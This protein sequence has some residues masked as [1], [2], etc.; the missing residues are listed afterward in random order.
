[1]RERNA[2]LLALRIAP[3]PN[4][5][6]REMSRLTRKKQVV[7]IPIDVL[8]AS[9]EKYFNYPEAHILRKATLDKIEAVEEYIRDADETP[10]M[11][12]TTQQIEKLFK[13]LA[14]NKTPGLDRISNEELKHSLG[15]G[16]TIVWAKFLE[17]IYNSGQAPDDFNDG[18]VLSIIKKSDKPNDSI[19]N[20]RPITISNSFSNVQER[21]LLENILS[22]AKP[23]RLQFGFRAKTSTNHALA[24][25]NEVIAWAKKRKRTYT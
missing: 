8:K 10:H 1:M 19:N 2:E 13:G 14:N 6:W 16:V 4:G 18:V 22:K 11:R 17:I 23:H 20:V 25:L 24:L 15:P 12:I 9:F 3:D 21:I 7:D 5:F